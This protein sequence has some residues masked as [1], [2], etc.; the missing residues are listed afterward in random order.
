V[1]TKILRLAALLFAFVALTAGA[2]QF[3]AFVDLRPAAPRG[4]DLRALGRRQRSDRNHLFVV[5][6]SA[7]PAARKS[8]RL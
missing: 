8:G 1:S 7:H 3:G 2:L 4:C 6:R 5:S